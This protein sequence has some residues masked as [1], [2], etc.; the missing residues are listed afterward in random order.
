MTKI[1]KQ[2]R[3]RSVYLKIN[4]P[5][6]PLGLFSKLFLINQGKKDGKNEIPYRIEDIWISPT[7]RTEEKRVEKLITN[8][9]AFSNRKNYRLYV[10]FEQSVAYFEQRAIEIKTLHDFLDKKLGIYDESY[11]T[12]NS[13]IS[14]PLDLDLQGQNGMKAMLN[15]K[16]KSE[17][18]AETMGI[19][20]R[21]F[22]E[23]Q[24][25][26]ND[27]RVRYNLAK[28]ELEQSFE[29]IVAI[30]ELLV[31]IDRQL[32][33]LYH[34]FCA[35]V[36]MRLAWYWQGVLKKHPQKDKIQLL[37]PKTEKSIFDSL[38]GLSIEKLEESMDELKKTRNMTL[39]LSI[40]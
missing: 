1:S 32:N 16:R 26:M 39:E 20:I 30:Y 34:G 14:I 9:S 21:R 36:N 10:Q 17:E 15:S 24:K 2:F 7:I 12:S 4:Q 38:Y 29:E 33:S 13:D 19:R 27:L 31:M 23:Y 11:Y 22:K 25:P 18:N 40:E 6:I 3:R 28:K 5:Y 35:K 37:V 8:V